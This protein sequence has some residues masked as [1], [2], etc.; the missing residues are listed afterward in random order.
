MRSGWRGAGAIPLQA[1]KQQWWHFG[2]SHDQ[3]EDAASSRGQ[4]Q[5]PRGSSSLLPP[6]VEGSIFTACLLFM[7]KSDRTTELTWILVWWDVNHFWAEVSHF[8]SLSHCCTHCSW[9][10]GWAGHPGLPGLL[11]RAELGCRLGVQRSHIGSLVQEAL[12]PFSTRKQQY[13]PWEEGGPACTLGISLP[14]PSPSPFFTHKTQL[15]RPHICNVNVTPS[16]KLQGCLCNRTLH[17]QKTVDWCWSFPMVGLV[18]WFVGFFFFWVL[19]TP[20]VTCEFFA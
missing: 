3:W 20:I 5:A 7:H 18:C 4:L 15:V 17:F 13:R 1:S 14:Y 12:R 11:R 2:S 19:P 6:F 9:L 10:R 16:A 8:C